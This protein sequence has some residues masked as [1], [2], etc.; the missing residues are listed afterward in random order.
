MQ[1]T[2]AKG[3]FQHNLSLKPYIGGCPSD[4]RSI[5]G[6]YEVIGNPH[7]SFGYNLLVIKSKIH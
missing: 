5:D 4:L 1:N 2:T 7:I 3:E 6:R